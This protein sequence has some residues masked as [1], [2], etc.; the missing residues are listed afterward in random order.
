MAAEGGE[1]L[2][3][4]ACINAGCEYCSAHIG[5]ARVAGSVL[6]GCHGNK[7]IN[8]LQGEMAGRV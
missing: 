2:S 1:S 6:H 5:Y 3:I 7:K 8:E 4:A